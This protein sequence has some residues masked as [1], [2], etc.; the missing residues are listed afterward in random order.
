MDVVEWALE[1]LV[2]VPW[3]LI[4]ALVVISRGPRWIRDWVEA[5]QVIRETWGQG[6]DAARNEQ[7]GS[8]PS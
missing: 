5:L 6:P 8:P 4:A 7:G 2:T 1:Q 3:W